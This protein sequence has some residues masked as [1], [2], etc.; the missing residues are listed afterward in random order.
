MDRPT[1]KASILSALSHA[2]DLVEGQPEGHA[3]RSCHLAMRLGQ[4]ISLSDESM[5]DLFF[6][7]LLKDSG[8]SNN[9]VRI[10]NI[11]GGNEHLSK[12]AVK[13]IDWTSLSANLRF[14][15]H[16][17]EQGRSLATKLK[18]MAKNLGH[19]GTLM[20][21]VTEARCTRG[22]EIAAMLGC[23]PA[24]AAA[25][26]YLD[27]H[28]DGNG[29]PYGRKG[30][31][32]SIE[33][34]I[35]CLCQTFEV[36][37]T[38]FGPEPAYDVI[39][40]RSGTW[41]DPELV[42]AMN[43][44]AGHSQFWVSF[45]P[46]LDKEIVNRWVPHLDL[47]APD[48]DVD[49]ICRAFAMIVDAKSSYTAQHSNRVTN[50][51]LQIGSAVGLDRDQMIDLRRASLLHDIGKLGVPAG[52]LEKAGKLDEEEFALI[53]LHPEYSFKILERVPAFERI[54]QIASAHH[55]RLDGK[56]Y[57]Q[58]LAADDL[59]TSMRILAVADVFDALCAERPYKPAMP[60]E[61][62]LAIMESECESALDPECV[63][64]LKQSVMSGVTKIAA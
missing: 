17:T 37:L 7:A 5:E 27:E 11:F 16:F 4:Q 61:R 29:A 54:A 1:S 62:A 10:H 57:W 58:G 48:V 2:L 20:R 42:S 55:E 56:G 22:A 53:K 21:E 26:Q 23:R 47:A 49:N 31:D 8:C 25:I 41:F 50:Y 38:T 14:A 9:S 32:I 18:R 59:D 51:A 44:I 33:A 24:A 63:A 64:I 40:E 28:W 43:S 19:P 13:F 3:I 12:Q 34:R 30:D 35:L 36:F 45:T 52:I 39:N 6:A 46:W 60:A 15:F